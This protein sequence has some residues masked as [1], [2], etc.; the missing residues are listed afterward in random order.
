MTSPNP[1]YGFGP[2]G[3][4]FPPNVIVAQAFEGNDFIITTSG[5]FFYSGA[6][7]AGNLV[8]SWTPPGVTSDPFGNTVLADAITFYGSAGNKI[9]LG[10]VG[11]VTSELQFFTGA[12]AEG[13]AANV[14]A[15]VSGSGTAQQM[16]ELISG[17]KGSGASTDDWVQVELVSG[18][19]SGAAKAAM[20]LNYI[21][22]AGTVHSFFELL[23]TGVLMT[24]TVNNI[25]PGAFGLS[26]PGL[27]AG[28]PPS[29]TGTAVASATAGALLSYLTA[30][31]GT[32]NLSVTA[33][34]NVVNGLAGWGV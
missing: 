25:T 29:G 14:S 18:S 11:G 9:A 24:G 21:D 8:A 31:E 15:G 2:T 13:V 33:I 26:N 32:Y 34:Q 10:L 1:G 22:T 4:G 30:L 12:A 23:S 7:G 19:P 5:M 17:P 27:A 6:P 20:F 16:I 28:A 3:F